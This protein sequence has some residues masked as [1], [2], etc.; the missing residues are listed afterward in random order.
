M[1]LLWGLVAFGFMAVTQA[2]SLVIVV[3]VQSDAGVLG[4]SEA[5]EQELVARSVEG[6]GLSVATLLGAM[7]CTP[8]VLG[9]AKLKR[10]SR[11]ND[12]FY[13]RGFSPSAL[14]IWAG[15]LLVFMVGSAA[16]DALVGQPMETEFMTSAYETATS[17]L[18]LAIA[19]VVAAPLFEEVLFRG[20]M[21]SGL[22][23]SFLG[24]HGAVLA[25]SFLW[26]S[27]HVQYNL[28]LMGI[29]FSLGVVLGY[30][31]NHTRSLFVPII[32]HAL[33]NLVAFSAT[34]LSA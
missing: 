7:V 18:M 24:V 5:L 12:Y 27:I 13:L 16:V 3:F 17:P 34:A 19:L 32:L 28:Y 14:G 23:R 31:R 1:T 6:D 2:L 26:A 33:N 9:V 25:T 20:F 15:A 8:L 22:E 10:G 29:I 11:L 30:A 21:Q 4:N